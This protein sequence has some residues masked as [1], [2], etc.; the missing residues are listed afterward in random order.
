MRDI[1]LVKQR[2]TEVNKR[3][4]LKE[5]RCHGGHGIRPRSRNKRNRVKIESRWVNHGDI[6]GKRNSRRNQDQVPVKV[7]IRGNAK[8]VGKKE[9]ESAEL[10][11]EAEVGPLQVHLQTSRMQVQVIQIFAEKEVK[12]GDQNADETKE[13]DQRKDHHV[14][15]INKR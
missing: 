4:L 8:I 10:E 2:V 12:V 13:V 9:Q 3:R 6:P 7:R 5:R 1:N 14:I 11:K 15:I